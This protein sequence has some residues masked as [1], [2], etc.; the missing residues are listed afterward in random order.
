MTKRYLGKSAEAVTI[1]HNGEMTPAKWLT[2][3][4]P[5]LV[6]DGV[7]VQAMGALT[8]DPIATGGQ[9]E[10]SAGRRWIAVAVQTTSSGGQ[11][12]LYDVRLGE[13]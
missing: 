6:R 12:P 10:D 4:A 5:E 7:V 13:A 2:R 8:Y 3:E 9:V 1:R 11:H